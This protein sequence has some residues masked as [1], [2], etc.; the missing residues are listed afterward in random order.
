MLVKIYE[1]SSLTIVLFILAVSL[2]QCVY[3]PF[4]E[5]DQKLYILQILEKMQLKSDLTMI[6]FIKN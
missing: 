1:L 4:T 2:V 3:E 5:L 6:S